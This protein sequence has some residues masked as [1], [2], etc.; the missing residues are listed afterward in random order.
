MIYIT[1]DLAV[2]AQLADGIMV[3]RYGNLIEEN[4]ARKIL[5]SPKKEYTRKLLSVRSLR[6]DKD[7][8]T[9]EKD[10]VLEVEDVSVSYTG[11]EMVLS[12]VPEMDPDW[13]DG[14]LEMRKRKGIKMEEFAQS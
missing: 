8:S 5:A 4:N 9:S 12:S 6:E 7:L 2:V 14:V 11:K 10:V 3:L 1:H 13:L